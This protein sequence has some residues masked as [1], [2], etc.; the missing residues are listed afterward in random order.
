MTVEPLSPSMES[1]STYQDRTR[2]VA[3]RQ[4]NSVVPEREAD[5]KKELPQLPVSG[6]SLF[7]FQL[8]RELGRGAFACVYLAHQHDLAGRPVVLK[9]SGVDGDEPQTLAQLQHTHIVPIYSVHEDASKGLRAVCMPYFGGASLSRVLE[10]LWCQSP[11]PRQGAQLTEALHAIEREAGTQPTDRWTSPTALDWL[12]NQ[13]YTRAAAW[14][15]ERLA[16]ALQH[17]HQRGVVHCDIKPS[18]ILL[19]SEGEPMLLD[20]NVS[21]NL[22]DT[23]AKAVVGGTV[24]Y[25]APEHLKALHADDSE[26]NPAD[27]RSDIYSLGIVLYEMVV[28]CRPFTQTGGYSQRESLVKAMAVERSFI[29][30]SLRQSRLD[31]PWSLESILRKCLAPDP[32]ARYQH[33][34][35]LAED[36][37]RFLDDRPLR[38]AP[39]LSVSESLQKWIRRHPRISSASTV[40][41]F[42]GFLMMGGLWAISNYRQS[43]ESTQEHLAISQAKNLKRQFQEGTIRAFCYLNTASEVVNHLENGID[44]CEKTLNTFEILKNPDWQAAT[45]WNRLSVEDQK[46]LGE[47]ARELLVI[48]AWAKVRLAPQNTQEVRSALGLLEIAEQ[49]KG[50]APCR[51]LWEERARFAGLMNDEAL[52]SEARKNA[53]D[54][55]PASARDFYLMSTVHARR[56]EYKLAL[57]D[58]EKALALSP[59]HY[60]ARVQKG[61]CHQELG[62]FTLAAGDFGACIGLWPEF[63][64]GYFNRAYVLEKAGHRKSAIADYSAAIACDPNFVLGFLNRGMAYLEEKQHEEAL[65]D[66]MVAQR[67]GRNDAAVHL[68]L[69]V[70]FEGL[71]KTEDAD[72]AFTRAFDLSKDASKEIKVRT[73]WIYGFAVSKRLP[74]QS[75]KAFEEVLTHVP[76]HQQARYGKAMLLVAQ[77]RETE[78]LRIFSRLAEETPPMAVARRYRAVLFA[79]RGEFDLASRDINWCLER[80]REQGPV[81]YAG[82]CVASRALEKTNTTAGRRSILDQAVVFLRRAWELGY[83][84]DHWQ[85]DPDLEALREHPEA[86]R[87]LDQVP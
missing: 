46:T 36:L 56:G 38:H 54:I 55:L 33:A 48:L 18:N 26:E 78:A 12:E 37:R 42:A 87:R 19:S 16:V 51:A 73:N 17:A 60:W 71:N 34:E 77:G 83:G 6:D 25:M 39:E 43:L 85:T 79:R 63:A 40:A 64:W 68:G 23:H 20:F 29:Q 66:L 15:L 4:S 13:T 72:L 61:I 50:L 1:K 41:A 32:N 47:D 75:E 81:F 35:H 65:K 30:P 52:G 84:R 59:R 31:V 45:A 49:I 74:D 7:G 80:E 58:V 44:H 69:G 2:R 62:E 86:M 22:H 11:Q 67:L 76:D 21:R 5:K 8:D 27:P 53:E 70:A 28:G 3:R 24:A 82:A 14:I 57:E 9:I 10:R